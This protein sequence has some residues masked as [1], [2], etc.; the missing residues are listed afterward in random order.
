MDFLIYK[1]SWWL[2]GALAI[3]FVIGWLSCGRAP[4]DQR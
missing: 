1:L 3:G 4:G 2:L